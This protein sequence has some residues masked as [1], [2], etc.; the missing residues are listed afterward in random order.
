VKRILSIALVAILLLNA[1]GYY[2]V[3]MGLHHKNDVAMKQ[4]LDSES[5]DLSN[6]ITI[7]IHVSIPYMTDQTDFE[8]VDGKIEHD[9]TLYR[10]VKQRYA[11]DTLTVVCIRDTQYRQINQALADYVKTFTDKAPD[12]KPGSKTTLNFLKDYLPTQLS[13]RSF[14]AGWS[15]SLSLS[16]ACKTFVPTFTTSIIHPPERA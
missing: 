15:S 6:T 11:D 3:F 12:S 4:S 7:R 1:L 13:I 9:G 5:Y 8:R 10:K 2:G 16:S 14:S